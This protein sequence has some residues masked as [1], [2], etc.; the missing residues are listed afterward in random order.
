M[1][2]RHFILSLHEYFTG[3]YN[4]ALGKQTQQGPKDYCETIKKC[5]TSDL[6][7]NGILTGNVSAGNCAHATKREYQYTTAWWKVYFHG[8]YYLSSIKIYRRK[9]CKHLSLT[10]I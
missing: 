2:I 4:I 5:H 10:I 9:D 3:S 7:V 6:A 8:E 1:K